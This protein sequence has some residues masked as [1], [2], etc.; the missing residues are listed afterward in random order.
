MPSS[1]SHSD[2]ASAPEAALE[3]VDALLGAVGMQHGRRRLLGA[4]YMPQARHSRR[5]PPERQQREKHTEEIE[6]VRSAVLER[7]GVAHGF[8]TRL[9]GVSTVY[10]ASEG[11]SGDLNLGF[12]GSDPEENVQENRRRLLQHVFGEPRQLVTLQQFHSNLVYRMT[13]ADPVPKA[14]LRGDGMMTNQPGLV[15]GIQTADC[16]PVLIADPKRGAVAAFHAG[17]RGTLK[18]IVEQGIGRMRLEFGSDPDGLRAAIGPSIGPCCYAVGEEVEHAF[19]SQ[20]T[21][22]EELF[23]EV[24]DSDPIRRKYPM[25]FL[26]QRAPGHSDLGPSI[27]LNLPEANRRQL[28]DAGLKPEHID[29]AGQCTECRTDLFFSYRADQGFCGRMLSVITSPGPLG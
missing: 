11:G 14:V 12:T 19:R 3:A 15:L 8:S 25:L 1:H 5:E 26:S 29:M 17:W 16:V 4:G 2:P 9:G 24:S 6:T 27:H 7:A 22:A 18:R 21:Y 23:C 28:L 13:R 10:G 20:F